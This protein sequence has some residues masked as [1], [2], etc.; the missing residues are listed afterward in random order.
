ML[1]YPEKSQSVVLRGNRIM[2]VFRGRFRKSF[3]HPQVL[4]PNK[5]EKFVIDLHQI[6]YT[7]KK[8]HHLMI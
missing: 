8:G 2:E 6:N 4:I 3:S 5:P 1:N 7:F